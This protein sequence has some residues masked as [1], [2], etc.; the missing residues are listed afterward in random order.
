MRMRLVCFSFALSLCFNLLAPGGAGL[1][2]EAGLRVTLPQFSVKLNGNVV[3]NQYRE[4]PLLVYKDITYFPMTWDDSRML[5]L[6]SYWSPENGLHINQAQVT[7]SYNPY[8][9]DHRNATVYNAQFPL[10]AIT[11]N[12]SSVD[13][14]HEMY[15]LLSF[16]DVTYFPLTW[17]FAHDEFGWD[18]QW[19]D[20]EGLTIQSHQS[21]YQA[22]S[23]VP[24]NIID[25]KWAFEHQ[26]ENVSFNI[27]YST[28]N[29]VAPNLFYPREG[30]NLGE[31]VPLR[32]SLINRTPTPEA[33]VTVINHDFEIQ[34]FKDQALIWRGK[35]P[36]PANIPL[37]NLGTMGI[38]FQWDQRDSDGKQVPAG[39]YSI[40]L[41]TPTTIE[42]TV[43]GKEGTFKEHIEKMSDKTLGGVFTIK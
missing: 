6:E 18:Y 25:G 21:D 11:I 37:K 5:G 27:L 15:P 35:P 36:A 24:L 29:N 2:S 1:A 26:Y 14:S 32:L 34:I 10:T 19:S 13:N 30:V 3:D 4:Y 41:Q 39:Q 43:D 23:S 22:P 40:Y 7:S 12:G 42:Y 28:G 33:E 38:P 31:P 16:R 20:S 17:R 9:S 8:K